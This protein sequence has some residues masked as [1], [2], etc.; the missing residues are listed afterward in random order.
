MWAVNY[1]NHKEWT[2]PTKVTTEFWL[3]G[4]EKLINNKSVVLGPLETFK[5]TH[6]SVKV[7]YKILDRIH[8][9]LWVSSMISDLNRDNLDDIIGKQDQ[10]LL[11]SQLTERLVPVGVI[12]QGVM[13]IKELCQEH[14]RKANPLFRDLLTDL[15]VLQKQWLD[16]V[17]ELTAFI[18]MD[19]VCRRTSEKQ[20]I[21][22]PVENSNA[23]DAKSAGNLKKRIRDNNLA[24]KTTV[25]P[26]GQCDCCG[27]NHSGKCNFDDPKY[28]GKA[29]LEYKTK[30]WSDSDV[31]KAY[32]V[33][34]RT[35]LNEN[36]TPRYLE[37]V[38]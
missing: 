10:Q 14:R 13:R 15:L 17:Q 12:P 27:K 6:L 29:N 23:Q 31:G 19:Q 32:A 28:K 22:Q 18:D 33:L 26:K 34:G 2:D 1:P 25:A 8:T 20:A 36:H 5:R 11:I 7:E 30:S 3:Q 38:H 24:A 37:G 16:K 4:L 35:S 21:A 9:S